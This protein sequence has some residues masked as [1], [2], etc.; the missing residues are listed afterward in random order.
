M[1]RLKIIRIMMFVKTNKT[2]NDK[3]DSIGVNRVT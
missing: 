2:S 3:K 1:M